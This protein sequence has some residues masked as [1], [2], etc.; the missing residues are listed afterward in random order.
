MARSASASATRSRNVGT[1][2]A[3]VTSIRRTCTPAWTGESTSM[4][5]DTGS[6]STFPPAASLV[7]SAVLY[8]H[9]AGSCSVGVTVMSS[10]RGELG[11]IVT[12]FQLST[13]SETDDDAPEEK[14]DAS[15][16]SK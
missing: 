14:P 8:C 10:G 6:N 4:V 15:G 16:G 3:G 2:D 1:F 13:R 11:Y 9:F 7:E 12:W 5:S